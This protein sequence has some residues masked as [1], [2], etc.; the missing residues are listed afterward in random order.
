MIHVLYVGKAAVGVFEEWMH[1]HEAR[2]DL[3]EDL[4]EDTHMTI[5]S[6]GRYM[7]EELGK[8]LQTY[9]AWRDNAI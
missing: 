2:N 1:A 3:L 4:G 8:P 7:L 6:T 5:Y 9:E